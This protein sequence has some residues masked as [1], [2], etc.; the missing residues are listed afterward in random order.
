MLPSAV[1]LARFQFAFVM[2]WHFLFPAF[3]I[4]LASYLAVLE[5]LWLA[6]GNAVYLDTFRYWL[7]VFAIAFA[8][9][10]VS[11]IVMS[12]QFGTNWAVFSDKAGPVIGPL[13]GYEV[14]TAFFLESGFLGV[15]L[16]GMK[17]VGKGLHFAATCIVAVGT[18]ISAFWILA[19][20]SWMQT[21][22][23]YSL[24]PDGHFMPE[25][26]FQIVFNPSFPFRFAH[27]VTGAYLT[28][29]LVVGAVG[30]FH[31]LRDYYNP[32]ARLMF[33][34]ALWMAAI[35]GPLQ[36][37]IGDLHGINTYH[38]QPAKVAA[39]EGDFE[40]ERGAA[41]YIIGWPDAAAERLDYAIGIPHLASLYLA[42]DWNAD[43][44]GLKDFP[45]DTWPTNLPLVFFAF[46]TM[47]GLGLLIIALGATSLWLR[48]RDA[49]YDTRWF[50]RWA[51]AMGPAGFIAVTA[52][53]IVTEAGR[54]PFTVYGLLRTADSIG[55]VAAPAV[56]A[57]LVA[58]IIV[59]FVVFGA[60]IFY[61]L[62]LFRQTPQEHDPGPQA[63]K[64]VRSAGITPGP[65]VAAGPQNS[66]FAE[67]AR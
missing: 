44:K 21:P 19:A 20:N 17:L 31:L 9:G 49:L 53:W 11:G 4:G 6:T 24:A 66:G 16:F 10:V 43:V 61:L 27:T 58:F 22:Q 18:L 38:H 48:T 34:M 39:M 54:Q 12:Y 50:Q 1:D 26:W 7:R 41:A 46:R 30:A 45:R 23:G 37:V 13:L 15:M 29:A 60:G 3:T 56:A 55:P 2:V 57:S 52:G 33:S 64:P 65:S 63:G 35:V 8:M 62:Y 25:S 5:G 28:T 51:V 14:L 36:A 67:G 32:R 42:H 47:V 40:R 59:Y